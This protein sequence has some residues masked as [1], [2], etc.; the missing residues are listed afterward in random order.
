MY[1][2]LVVGLP[3]QCRQIRDNCPRFPYLITP[4]SDRVFIV[5]SLHCLSFNQASPYPL[6]TF[7]KMIQ[8]RLNRSTEITA[9]TE[10][11]PHSTQLHY[12]DYVSAHPLA[13]PSVRPTGE[14]ALKVGHS[15]KLRVCRELTRLRSHAGLRVVVHLRHRRIGPLHLNGRRIHGSLIR[16]NVHGK[17]FTSGSEGKRISNAR[18]DSNFG[19][20]DSTHSGVGGIPDPSFILGNWSDATLG[21]TY[22]AG[23]AGVHVA[24]VVDCDA[25]GSRP[26]AVWVARVI[27]CVVY[28]VVC[29]VLKHAINLDRQWS[30]R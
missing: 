26:A 4:R 23:T 25:A 13:H 19:G 7:E 6:W 11:S 9:D 12:I 10:N 29:A 17:G 1:S 28:D 21:D 5:Q 30:P 16:D 20:G 14:R 15:A 3:F 22:L 18:S 24:L 2:C 27:R 8:F